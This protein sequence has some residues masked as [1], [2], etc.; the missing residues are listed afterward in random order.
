MISKWSMIGFAVS[1]AAVAG[2]MVMAYRIGR[3]SGEE[4]V[5]AAWA[6]QREADAVAT[7]KAKKQA[8]ETEESL[9]QHISSLKRTHDEQLEAIDRY[10]TLSV[11]RLRK[12]T[13][14]PDNY[15]PAPAEATGVK[16]SASCGADQLYREDAEV[17]LGIARDADAVRASLNEC[18]TA[19]DSV[20]QIT[21][22]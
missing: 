15:V 10:Y 14:R 11:E 13:T 18:R 7:A 2:L 1:C 6:K 19:Y 16:P 21:E 20:N 17:A 4:E 22:R 3:Y 5:R 12:R 9:R 8:Q